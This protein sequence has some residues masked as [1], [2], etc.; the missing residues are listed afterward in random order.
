MEGG[1]WLWLLVALGMIALAV[2]FAYVIKQRR[3]ARST[4]ER[5]EQATR[6]NYRQGG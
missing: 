3:S 1:G 6:E 5:R 4:R 2:A